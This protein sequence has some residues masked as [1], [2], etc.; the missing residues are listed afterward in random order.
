ML[1]TNAFPAFL[2]EAVYKNLSL[3]G[4]CDC[5]RYAVPEYLESYSLRRPMS[6]LAPLSFGWGEHQ[7]LVIVLYFERQL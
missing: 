1:S 6:I 3:K 4:S 2:S 7:T 5:L